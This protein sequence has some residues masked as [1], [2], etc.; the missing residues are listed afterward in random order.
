MI[1]VKFTVASTMFQI[2]K[3]FR[4]LEQHSLLS[5]DTETR[6]LYSKEERK[7]ASDYLKNE[8]ID[9]DSRTLALVV[10][11]NSGLSYPSLVEVTHFVFGLSESESRIIICY[12]QR[13]EIAVWNWVAKQ[14]IKFLVHNSL[15][16]LKI[17]FNRIGKLPKDY[18]DTQLLAKSFINNAQPWLAKVG[19]KELMKNDYE[20]SWTL[21]DEYE[22]EDLKEEKFLRY[23]SIDGAATFKLWEDIQCYMEDNSNVE[24]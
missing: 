24:N 14:N 10:A 9:V 20:P 22:P 1:K 7:E 21:I 12:D 19:L 17:M 5:L 15:Y 6:G 8:G 2:H 16:D 4:E 18:E 11:N 23:T 13:T 3:V